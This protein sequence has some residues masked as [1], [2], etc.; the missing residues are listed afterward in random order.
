MTKASTF[1][2]VCNIIADVKAETSPISLEHITSDSVLADIPL[3]MDSLDFAKM[4]I[5][6]EE[7]FGFVAEDEDFV[8]SSMKTVDDVVRIVNHRLGSMAS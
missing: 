4:V 7:E 2:R 1:D 3:A 8:V 6:L 5:S